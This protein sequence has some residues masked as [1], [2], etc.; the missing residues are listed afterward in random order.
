MNS[1]KLIRSSIGLV[2]FVILMSGCTE[3]KRPLDVNGS[4][5]EQ[6]RETD[7]VYISNTPPCCR[8]IGERITLELS[9]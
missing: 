1:Q 9:T 4:Q 5:T 8:H 3:K 7:I 6:S 2:L